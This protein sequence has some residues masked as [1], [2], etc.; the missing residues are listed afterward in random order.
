MEKIIGK[1]KVRCLDSRLIRCVFLSL[2]FWIR[3]FAVFLEFFW[4]IRSCEDDVLFFSWHTLGII[5]YTRT[6]SPFELN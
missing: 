6:A 5:P 1:K 4:K 3:W 2:A